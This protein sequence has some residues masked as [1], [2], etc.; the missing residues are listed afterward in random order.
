MHRGLARTRALLPK[1][2]AAVLAKAFR[3]ELVPQDP[4]DESA[5]VLLKR[6]RTPRAAEP[7]GR[8]REKPDVTTQKPKRKPKARESATRLA[9]RRKRH[10]TRAG[11]S[12]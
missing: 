4:N 7:P 12:S 8:K 11:P 1:L 10:V 5:S 3:G 9:G 2:E 6:I